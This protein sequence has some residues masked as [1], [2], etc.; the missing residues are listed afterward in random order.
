MLCN[1]L[2]N[3]DKTEM[4]LLRPQASRRKL[5]NYVITLNGLSLASCVSVKERKRERKMIIDVSPSVFLAY[6]M[7]GS[8]CVSL[9]LLVCSSGVWL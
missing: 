3:S 9:F 2:L 4:L 1:F 8:F 6:V 7:S 5:S